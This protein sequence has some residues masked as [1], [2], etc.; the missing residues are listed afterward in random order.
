MASEPGPEMAAVR[1]LE[2]GQD[3]RRLRARLYLPVVG[4]S[5]PF[6]LFI[7][8][9]GFVWGNLDT[10]D[11]ICR[12]LAR[13]SGAALL[14]VDYRL[15]P[16]H[17]AEAQIND[18][19]AS[20]AWA[21]ARSAE[22][23]LDAGRIALCGDSAG[24]AIAIAAA[25]RA[26][27]DGTKLRHLALFYPAL[28]PDCDSGSQLEFATGYMLT[29]EAMQ[30]FWECRLGDGNA[31]PLARPSHIPLQRLARLPPVSQVLAEYDVL[32]DEGA[33]FAARLGRAGVAVRSRIQPGTIHGFL[34]LAATREQ[35]ACALCD[36]GAEIGAALA[37]QVL[38]GGNE[39]A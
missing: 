9:G 22:L 36:I 10:H 21:R 4:E 24:G 29:R 26:A 25:I 7:H 37:P 20:L 34:S 28:D 27:E 15:S 35:A 2:I 16:E 18:A 19:L 39:P 13:H 23:G 1:D 31:D 17:G 38:A 33:A 32:R 6:V 12:S 30:W 14:A 3:D 5:L 11:A 8:G